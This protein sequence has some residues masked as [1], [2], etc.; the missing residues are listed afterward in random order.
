MTIKIN[1]KI[2]DAIKTTGKQYYVRDSQ[3]P[4]FAIRVSRAGTGTYVYREKFVYSNQKEKSWRDTNI[5]Y[6][7]D[8]PCKVARERAL[9]LFSS[10]AHDPSQQH[11]PPVAPASDG[12]TLGE[13]V[14]LH[15][16]MQCL[17]KYGVTYFNNK[18]DRRKNWPKYL[19]DKSL[20]L[21]KIIEHFGSRKALKDITFDD[22][23]TFHVKLS[24]R[25]PV[26]ANR[27]MSYLSA[28]FNEQIKKQK[29]HFNPCTFVER[30]EEV[31]N[32]QAV[33]KSVLPLFFTLLEYEKNQ[34]VADAI[35]FG[36]MSGCRTSEVLSLKSNQFAQDNYVDWENQEIRLYK[37]K[38]AKRKRKNSGF[39]LDSR[40]IS[41]PAFE[42]LLRHRKR[43][44]SRQHVFVN[45]NGKAVTYNQYKNMFNRIR[46]EL[47]SGE[48]YEN[49]TP[50]CTRHTFAQTLADNYLDRESLKKLMGL[51]STRMINEHYAKQDDVLMQRAIADVSKLQ[52]GFK[53][54]MT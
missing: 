33:P 54:G 49:I 3:Y 4:F 5:G 21:E 19:Y 27:Y 31:T 11:E 26:L 7:K 44:G 18:D 37:H 41:V 16:E 20:G 22:V 51:T 45:E 34:V 53:V 47:F 17:K 8:T 40:K 25:G 2:A 39:S 24:H 35:R 9:S 46:R 23:D 43:R 36:F 28:I 15:L 14:D 1:Q 29:L 38:T 6:T 30:N 13:A 48:E 42:I 10:V 50:Y 12:D 32:K 52:E